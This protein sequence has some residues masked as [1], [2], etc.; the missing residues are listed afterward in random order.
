MREQ[1]L[2]S[3]P[4][5]PHVRPPKWTPEWKEALLG[6]ISRILANSQL[7][8]TWI[9][10][11]EPPRFVHGS[12]QGICEL[13]GTSVEKQPDGYCFVRPLGDNARAIDSICPRPS[14]ASIYWGAVEWIRY[15]RAASGNRFQFRNPVMG[16]PFDLANFLLGTTRL[17]E[18]VYTE[19]ARVHTLQEK[20]TEVIIDMYR[21]LK[22]AAGGTLHAAHFGCLAN[23]F[24]LASECRSLVSREMFEEFDA[25]YLHRIG[26]ALGPYGIHSCGS[27]ER[28]IPCSLR[29]PNLKG[30][31]GQVRENDLRELCELAN[32]RV[33]LAV[34]PSVD[35][36][37]RY[38]WPDR[39]SFLQYVLETVPTQQAIELNIDESELP[40][41][42]ELYHSIRG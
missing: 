29:D 41:Y 19:P 5:E 11:L 7:P 36:D 21:A 34:G 1:A 32:G 42:R 20:T 13:F 30:M 14:E 10:A 15:A 16:G 40:L 3:V 22:D 24:D 27:W 35:L 38:T 33:L 26:Q 31:H 18:W 6:G 12:G 37:E 23:A 2:E 17:M 39:T 28:T 8:G 4:D 9:P 25:P